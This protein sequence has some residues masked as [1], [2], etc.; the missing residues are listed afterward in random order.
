M[1]DAPDEGYP[2]IVRSIKHESRPGV[3]V[4]L[5]DGGS[6][7]PIHEV[8]F[9]EARVLA[10][11]VS[12]EA[13][14][15]FT[16]DALGQL[17]EVIDA[18]GPDSPSATVHARAL[19]SAAVVAYARAFG[20]RV[21]S[22]G[23]PLLSREVLSGAGEGATEFHNWVLGLRN[24]HVAHSV[25]PYEQTR[26]GIA[27][28]AEHPPSVMGI[29]YLHSTHVGP[30]RDGVE[31]FRRLTTWVLETVRARRK[32]LEVDAL[33]AADRLGGGEIARKPTLRNVIP[34]PNDA[35]AARKS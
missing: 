9:A 20:G 13:D 11:A 26:V 21:R 8:R 22:G 34:G 7:V 24:K 2:E 25:N 1:P 29:A 4:E 18:G 27:L 12:I 17:L 15:G 19:W 3:P 10:E 31:Q 23:A 33:A 14:L 30:D 28:G 5:G 16:I 6:P 32:S 35:A